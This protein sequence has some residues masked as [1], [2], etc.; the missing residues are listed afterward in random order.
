MPEELLALEKHRH[1]YAERL[2]YYPP[3]PLAE[4]KVEPE[5]KQ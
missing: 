3:K 4:S 2:V 1:E 5:R